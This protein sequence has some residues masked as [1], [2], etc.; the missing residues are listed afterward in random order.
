MQPTQKSDG[1]SDRSDVRLRVEIFDALMAREGAKSVERQAEVL[2]LHRSTLFRI[3]S[4]ETAPNL[5]TAMQMAAACK[6]TVD[7][8]FERVATERVA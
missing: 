5:T 6:T 8:L 7:A 2:G 1:T 3:R 4:G